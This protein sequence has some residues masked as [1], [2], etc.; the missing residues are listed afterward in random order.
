MLT[1]DQV[2][3]LILVI[4]TGILLL[5]RLPNIAFFSWRHWTNVEPIP[6]A[7]ERL[8]SVPHPVARTATLARKSRLPFISLEE[9]ADRR[10]R[11]VLILLQNTS[12]KA[13][14]P[15]KMRLPDDAATRV[16]PS[17]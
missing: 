6:S 12:A 2:S 11:H 15:L 7:S 10:E 16:V 8:G 13:D 3:T 4:R 9:V 17:Q 5:G 1:S 14:T